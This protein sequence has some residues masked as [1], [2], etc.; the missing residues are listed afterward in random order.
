M[1][2]RLAKA[3]L[4]FEVSVVDVVVV[5]LQAQILRRRRRRGFDGREKREG[6]ESWR[7]KFESI[8]FF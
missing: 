1:A 5:F 2:M 6:R 4:Y 7:E 8:L 3:S